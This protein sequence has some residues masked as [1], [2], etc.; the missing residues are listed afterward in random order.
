MSSKHRA[1]VAAVATLCAGAAFAP[2][3]AQAEPCVAE[4]TPYGFCVSDPEFGIISDPP[5]YCL[6]AGGEWVCPPPWE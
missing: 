3:P 5:W 2:A 1:V 6:Y 4:G